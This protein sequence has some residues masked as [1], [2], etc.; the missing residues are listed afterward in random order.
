MNFIQKYGFILLIVI[1]CTAF[2]IV[3]VL[4]ESKTAANSYIE[5]TIVEG[6]TLWGLAQG[7]SQKDSSEKWIAKVMKLNEMESTTIKTGET[8]KLPQIDPIM[9]DPMM[10][11]LAGE[12]K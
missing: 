11:E 4:K 5:V 2:T 3:G 6:D 1:L 12:E 7:Y 8:L 9:P 10:T